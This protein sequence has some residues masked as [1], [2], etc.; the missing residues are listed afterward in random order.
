MS[1]LCICYTS[2]FGENFHE[3]S[4]LDIAKL[5]TMTFKLL[6]GWAL[7]KSM[8]LIKLFKIKRCISDLSEI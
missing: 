2:N 6:I 8:F 4:L 5:W 3:I 1:V 7:L